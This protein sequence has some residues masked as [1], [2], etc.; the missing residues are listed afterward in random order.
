M[1]QLKAVNEQP[2]VAS[3]KTVEMTSELRV[4]NYSKDG[5]YGEDNLRDLVHEMDYSCGSIGLSI[6][7]LVDVEILLGHLVEGMNEA[8]YK[9][10]EMAYYK[11]H[12]RKLRVYQ[13]LIHHTVN[14][15]C[16]EHEKAETLKDEIFNKV[17]KNK[18]H[19]Q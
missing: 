16:T 15:L 1:D 6:S 5:S 7:T 3:F 4:T 8:V 19:E 11:E 13:N 2:I 9:G 17:V 10:E 18:T 14:E 12:H